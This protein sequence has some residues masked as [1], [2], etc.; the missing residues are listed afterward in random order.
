MIATRKNNRNIVL[1]RSQHVSDSKKYPAKTSVNLA[2]GHAA[3]NFFCCVKTYE[4][5]PKNPFLVTKNI[6]EPRK[7][8]FDLGYIPVNVIVQKEKEE[9]KKDDIV[10]FG[11]ASEPNVNE[12]NTNL[13]FLHPI[14]VTFVSRAGPLFFFC[15]DLT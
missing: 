13:A 15:H 3:T 5:G 9:K 14:K 7:G 4:T 1:V 11:N 10:G 8:G 6:S 2:L 12:D